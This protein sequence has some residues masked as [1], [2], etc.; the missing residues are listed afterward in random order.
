MKRQRW[1]AALLVTVLSIG[2]AE[3]TCASGPWG[4]VDPR[5]WILLVPVYGFETLLI[6]TIVV[7]TNPRPTLLALWCTGVVMGL[8]EFYITH[9]L[10]DAPWTDAASTGL[11]EVPELLVI[12]MVWHPFMSVILPILLAE[13]IMV[14]SPTLA[15]AL[16]PRLRRLSPKAAW[17][18]L[19]GLALLTAGQYS[20]GDPRI[21]PIA[22]GVSVFAVWGTVVL[23]RRIGKVGSLAD[24][25]PTRGGIIG[26]VAGLALL[27]GFFAANTDIDMWERDYEWEGV[28]G[29]R[30]ATAIVLYAL[31]VLLAAR[32][33]RHRSDGSVVRF[34]WVPVSRWSALVY[35]GIASA[36]AFVPW[37][38]TVMAIVLWIGGMFLAPVLFVLAVRGA[39]VRVGA[40][41][42]PVRS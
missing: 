31:F 41:E 40:G 9:V 10:W 5:G 14:E 26:L 22:L 28:S 20:Q 25:M 18:A 1:V 21:T 16:P 13:Q 24:V 2:L 39:L 42:G 30:Q 34:R 32:N 4:L 37:S 29:A 35:V 7:R 36:I 27:F 23:V 8:Y 6:A 38:F 11:V 15:S 19:I 17:A 3:V 12:A 33:L